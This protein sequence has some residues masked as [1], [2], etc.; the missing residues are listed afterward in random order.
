[1]TSVTAVF[2]TNA[3]PRGTYP[4]RVYSVSLSFSKLLMFSST[5]RPQLPPPPLY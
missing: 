2:L 5:A 4:L 1:V 3:E